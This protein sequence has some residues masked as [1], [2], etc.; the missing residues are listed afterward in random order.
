MNRDISKITFVFALLTFSFV[1]ISC[2]NDLEEMNED[3]NR[4]ENPLTYGLFN[5]ANKNLMDGTRDSFQSGRAA[6]L[7]MQYGAQNNY[8]DEDRYQYRPTTPQSLWNAY[9]GS[10]NNYK[11][12][13]ELNTDEETAEL[14]SQYGPTDNQI[15]AARVMLAYIFYNLT[16]T[17]GDVPYY[18]YG[19]D[20]EDFQA[21]NIEETRTPKFA[22]QEEIYTDILKELGEAVEMID[23]SDVVFTEGDQLFS[24]GGNSS[25]EKLKIFANSLRLKI[26]TRVKDVLPEAEDAIQEAIAS[27]VMESNDHSVGLEYENNLVN[28]S[29]P[30]SWF[31]EGRSDFNITNTLVD[32]LKGKS[33]DFG[34]DPRLFKY[35][36]PVGTSVGAILS[37]DDNESTDPDD[38]VGLPY[39]VEDKVASAQA[40]LGVSWWSS[41]V[42]KR[43]FTEYLMEYSE[44]EF[45]LSE[46]ENWNQD[47]FEKGVEASMQK[48]GVEQGEID[49]FVANL[50]AASEETVITQKWAALFMQ[51]Y[52]AW[53]E[54]RRTG[55]PANNV[56]LT[57]GGQG[58]L[59]DGG[60]YTFEPKVGAGEDLPARLTYPTNLPQ[61][62]GDNYEEAVGRLGD[63]NIDT[64]LIWA[65]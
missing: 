10:A 41:N 29:E 58:D 8:T 28:P 27:G 15:A 39:G 59:I 17:F 43:D 50:P 42:I 13:I 60:T 19:T 32:F 24:I 52:E 56:I 12:I 48:W 44:V 4:T 31:N 38:I 18:S 51:P 20:N 23:P 63:D 45:L 40:D 5:Y 36:A 14:M 9:Y 11:E 65:K 49:S 57:P 46:A 35:A 1:V 3:P 26:A 34:L 21:L 16:D 6:L 30:F 37:E 47:H 64:K 7:W 62:N 53:A 54:Y 61:L 2:T 25:G 33:G 55:Y 22:E